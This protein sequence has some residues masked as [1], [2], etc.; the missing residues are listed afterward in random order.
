MGFPI[1]GDPQ[2]GN[3]ESVEYSLE[4]GIE[5]QLLC[6]KKLEFSHPVSGEKMAIISQLD[7]D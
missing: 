3:P 6:A 4:K 1:L 2:Y 7:T 5:T